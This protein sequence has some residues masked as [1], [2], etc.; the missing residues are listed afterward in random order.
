M[1]RSFRLINVLALFAGT[2]A[3][4]ELKRAVFGLGMEKYNA[5]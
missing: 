3:R 5:N 4:G 1:C 2:V